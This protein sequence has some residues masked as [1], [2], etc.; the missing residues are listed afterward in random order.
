MLTL[1]KNS[2]SPVIFLVSGTSTIRR[3]QDLGTQEAKEREKEDE[4]ERIQWSDKST[5]SLYGIL[6]LA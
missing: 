1:E 2:V 5:R 3:M 6:L 4:R